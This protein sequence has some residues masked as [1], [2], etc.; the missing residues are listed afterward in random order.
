MNKYSII[1]SLY[2]CGRFI[3]SY[4]K[5]IFS[6][7]ILPEEIIL[8]DDTN[9][10]NNLNDI[11]DKKKILYNFENIF[12]IINDK[13][14]G[15]AISLNKAIKICKNELI[16]RLDVDDFWHPNHTFEMISSYN[17]NSTF[18]IYANS[19]KKNNFLNR[20][21]CDNYLINE[22]HLISSSWLINKRICKD[23]KFKLLGPKLGLEDYFTL[24]YYSRKYKFF[25]NYKNTVK[26][27]NTFDSF[28]KI[29][30]LNKN[31]FKNRKKI[32]RLFFSINIKNK[33]LFQRINFILFKFGIIKTLIFIILYY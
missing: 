26:Y 30:S 3:D 29:L 16:F 25:W 27:I 19:V 14:L 12:L 28:S 8:I 1:T 4:F 18:L 31:Y 17:E 2:N 23:F 5:T 9:N 6:Q 13:N 32:S 20:I 10:P 24:L 22:N 7:K 21:K 33:N 11:L 15:P